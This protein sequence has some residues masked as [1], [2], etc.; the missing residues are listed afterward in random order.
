MATP[1]ELLRDFIKANSQDLHW[2]EGGGASFV[3]PKYELY[4]R[5]YLAFSEQELQVQ[6]ESGL[7]NCVAHL[8]RAMDCQLSM[9]LYALGLLDMFDKRNLGIDKRLEFLQKCGIFSAR[10]LS[11]LN[12]KR[13]KMEHSYE[14]PKIQDLEAYF[15]L[16]VAFVSVLERTAAFVAS[17]RL[18][19][20]DKG[21]ESYCYYELNFPLGPESRRALT[22]SE[23]A[24]AEVA[25]EEA[26]AKEAVEVGDSYLEKTAKYRFS[27]GYDEEEPSITASW[28]LE[29]DTQSLTVTTDDMDAFAYFLRVLILLE[30]RN[31]YNDDNRVVESLSEF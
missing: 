20:I 5:D 21:K 1:K 18:Y 2:T 23:Y 28:N 29:A 25:R 3:Y 6:S 27:M 7:I 11:R 12:A 13:N 15:D 24:D 22:E 10:T 9:F 17:N 16:V 8:K 4:A 14:V 19:D 31:L 30:I 26:E